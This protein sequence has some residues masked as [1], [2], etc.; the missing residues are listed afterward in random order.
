MFL[1]AFSQKKISM[2]HWKMRP[3]AGGIRRMFYP[4]IWMPGTT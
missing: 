2:K 4:S 3:G 1:N